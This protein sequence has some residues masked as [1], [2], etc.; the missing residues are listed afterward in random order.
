MEM[1]FP[2]SAMRQDSVMGRIDHKAILAAVMSRQANCRT[3]HA[4]RQAENKKRAVCDKAE[5]RIHYFANHD[6]Q[7]MTVCGAFWGN[8]ITKPKFELGVN[9]A[10]SM[11]IKDHGLNN[12]VTGAQLNHAGHGALRTI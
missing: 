6:G 1:T 7:E 5:Q 3:V 2:H 11:N 8:V 10:G 9:Q 12:R 4:L